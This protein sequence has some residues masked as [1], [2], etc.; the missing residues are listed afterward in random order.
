MVFSAQIKIRN[1]M[2]AWGKKSI[3]EHRPIFKIKI[4]LNDRPSWKINVLE[5]WNAV[6][7]NN[8]TNEV[9][10]AQFSNYNLN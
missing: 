3:A 7:K 4:F 5:S 9:W 10:D 1:M 6:G 2:R 8:W